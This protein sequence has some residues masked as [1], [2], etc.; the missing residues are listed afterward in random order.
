MDTAEVNHIFE[1]F[2]KMRAIVIGDAMIDTYL[3]GKVDRISP[4]VPVPIVTVTKRENRLGGAANVSHNLLT[5][6]ATPVL[7][8]VIG[9]DDKGNTF[10]KLLGKREISENGIVVDK[11]RTTT[12]KNRIISNGKHIVRVDEES[13]E[14]ISSA[15]EKQLIEKITSEINT[16]NIDVIIFVDYDKGVITPSLFDAVNKLALEKGIPTAVDPKRRNFKQYKKVSLFKPNFKEFIEGSGVP[17]SKGDFDTIKKVAKKIKT[18]QNLKL[19]SVTLSELGMFISN[20]TE[21]QHFP[22]AIRQISDVSGAGDTAISVAGLA[23][24]AGLPPKTIAHMSNL[25]G[26]LV[27][28]EIGVVP[29]NKKRLKKEMKSKKI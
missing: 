25:A 18:Q 24:A 12:V 26:G 20:G 5:L 14:Y 21:E 9:D 15:I 23:L 28:E 8:S 22:V 29:I 17:I 1:K 4:E 16:N 19:V 13:T 7:F 2:G 11:K 3:W 27:C 10:K 6:G